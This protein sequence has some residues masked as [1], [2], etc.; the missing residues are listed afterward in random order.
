MPKK[1]SNK[2]KKRAAKERAAA[3]AAAPAGGAGS[4]SSPSGSPSGRGYQAT[5][6]STRSSAAREEDPSRAGNSA[7]KVSG[8]AYRQLPAIAERVCGCVARWDAA[9]EEGVSLVG[10]VVG[11]GARLASIE[12]LHLAKARG[13]V[14]RLFGGVH[15]RLRQR[16]VEDLEDAMHNLHIV[17]NSLEEMVAELRA[18]AE[19]ALQLMAVVQGDPALQTDTA[20]L[21]EVAFAGPTLG[22]PV[23]LEALVRCTDDLVRE[24]AQEY[25]RKYDLVASIRYTD[26]ALLETLAGEWPTSGVLSP[27]NAALVDAHVLQLGSVVQ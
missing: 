16:H 12:K 9:D 22:R 5:W 20:G 25:W 21:L 10:A 6:G 2:K 24:F 13:D 17:L 1:K 19:D 26:P 27:F 4:C 7:E 14:L 11:L 18:C 23:P 15:E 8:K 3:A